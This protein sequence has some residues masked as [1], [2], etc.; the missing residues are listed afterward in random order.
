MHDVEWG[1]HRFINWLEDLYNAPKQ[2]LVCLFSYFVLNIF[3]Y[4]KL[5][6]HLQLC[7]GLAYLR[8][9]VTAQ[10]Y[11]ERRHLLNL[12][13]STS[14]D[15]LADGLR[16]ANNDDVAQIRELLQHDEEKVKDLCQSTEYN[17][18]H[19]SGPAK[20]WFWAHKDETCGA[21]VFADEHQI[22][23]QK[24]YVMWDYARLIRLNFFDEAWKTP[25]EQ[26]DW[27]E[28]DAQFEAMMKSFDERSDIWMR[29]GS[30]WWSAGDT[31]K[32][33]WPKEA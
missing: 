14:N 31:S 9:L 29:G 23:R 3:S 21:F 8:Q 30:G 4:L 13:L 17:D 28:R 7:T 1:G 33:I 15:M 16:E 11:E 6:F 5:T 25:H 19:D 26:L 2:H 24:A 12:K 32:V 27:E 18:D 20:A 10:S 22:L